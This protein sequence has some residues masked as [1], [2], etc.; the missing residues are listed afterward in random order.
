MDEPIDLDKPI[1]EE[2]V[3]G[4]W[5]ND[6]EVARL[7]LKYPD[8]RDKWTEGHYL[9]LAFNLRERRPELARALKDL[10]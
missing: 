1:P 6:A 4:V 9:A 10:R 3:D 5:N 8:L 2:L 7:L